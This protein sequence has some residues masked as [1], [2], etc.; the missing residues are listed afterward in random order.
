MKLKASDKA[1]ILAELDGIKT[2]VENAECVAENEIPEELKIDEEAQEDLTLDNAN[3]MIASDEDD[4]ESL[5]LEDEEKG[6]EGELTA[7]DNDP[8]VNVKDI[9]KSADDDGNVKLSCI[10]ALAEIPDDLDNDDILGSKKASLE[11]PGPEDKIGDEANG[12]DPSTSELKKIV[13]EIDNVS[14][15]LRKDGKIKLAWRL[16]RVSNTLEMKWNLK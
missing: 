1:R 11:K 10:K 15:D 14:Q 4:I 16:D 13:G 2:E 5:E 3:P 7:C 9:I 12:G 6:E 8:V